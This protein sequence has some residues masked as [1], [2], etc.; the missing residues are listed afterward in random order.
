MPATPGSAY[1]RL[2]SILGAF[3]LL[4]IGAAPARADKCTGAKLKDTGK[5]EAGLLS[6]ESQVAAKN[7][8]SGLSACEMKVSGKFSSAFGKAGSCIGDEMSCEDI[9]DACESTVSTAL[10]DTFPSKCEAAKRKAAGKLASGELGC[11]AKAAVKGVGLDSGCIL[12]AQ[13]RFA[14]AVSKAGSCPDGGSP[15]ALVESH[16]VMPAVTTDGS[17]MVTDVCPTTTTTTTTT[18]TTTTTASTTT[19]TTTMGTT[20]TTLATTTKCGDGIVDGTEQCDPPGVSCTT[21][22]NPGRCD[23]NCQCQP[24]V[25]GNGITEGGE[26]CDDGAANGTPGDLCDANCQTVKTAN[27]SASAGGTVSTASGATSTFPVAASVTT[28]NAGTVTIAV[29]SNATSPPAGVEFI[30][31]EVD[32]TAPGAGDATPLSLTFEIDNSRIRA[33]ENQQTIEVFR[34]GTALPAC[35]GDPGTAVPDPCVSQRTTL[36]NGNV[37]ITALS[38]AASTWTLGVQVCGNTM[39][40]PGEQCD[41]PGQQ[42][43]CSAGQVCDSVCQCGAPCDCCALNPSTLSFTSSVASG[44]CGTLVTST[45]SLV[46]NLACGGFYTGG[47][48]NSVPL[49]FVFPDQAQAVMK[50][51]GCDSVSGKITLG[52]TSAT[53]TGSARTCTQAGCLFGAPIPVPNSA[54]TATSVCLV[55]TVAQDVTGLATC[56]GQISTL[57]VPISTELYLDGDLFPNAPGIQTCPVCNDTC[58]GGTNAG[59]PCNTDTD[60]PGGGTGSCAGPTVCHG[61]PNNGASC[62]PGDSALTSGLPTSQ[63]C[64][65]PPANAIGAIPDGVPL[66]TGTAS[67]TA[68]NNTASGQIN[69]FC[70]FCRDINAA[71]TGCFEGDPSPACPHNSGC[72]GAGNPFLCCTGAGAGTCDPQSLRSCTSNAQCTDGAGAWP[73]CEQRNAGAFGH[74]TARTIT[75]TGTPGGCFANSSSQSATLVGGFCIPPEFNPTVDAAADLPGPGAVSVQ[76][77][78]KLQ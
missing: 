63:D 46:E 52:A 59:G 48:S 2:V 69:V 65:P 8:M 6:C 35:L 61:G 62:S 28:P 42:A 3:V 47:G 53:D 16:C 76:G 33:G 20:T 45:G 30:G 75:E 14:G 7:A 56:G 58:S 23:A 64:P 25:C 12:K 5:K 1:P 55:N 9:A 60:C 21:G 37:Q 10:T 68:V 13:A 26:Q 15:Q 49:P 78:L 70:G 50:V 4:T 66:I 17:G 11:Y 43:E 18:S 38:K 27:Q 54:T 44:N 31:K 51:T 67:A 71:S 24:A 40:D 34:N 32:V 74:A 57:N 19:T 72:S 73:D 41:P 22:G 39:L 36:G 29:T 77:V